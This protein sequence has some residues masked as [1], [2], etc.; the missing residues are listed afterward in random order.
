MYLHSFEAFPEL[1]MQSLAKLCDDVVF[2]MH[3]VTSERIRE[4]ADNTHNARKSVEVSGLWTRSG[5]LLTCIEAAQE[6]EPDI[7]LLPDDDELLPADLRTHLDKWRSSE[8]QWKERFSMSFRQ[9]QCLGDENTIL[10][11]NVCRVGWHCKAVKWFDG[12]IE[13]YQGKYA[14]WCWPS[15]LYR[16]RKIQ[17]VYPMRHLAYA[18]QALID[19]RC[20]PKYPNTTKG[21]WPWY[22]KPRKTMPYDPKMTWKQWE[23]KAGQ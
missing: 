21:Q 22:E 5:S 11:E 1:A 9:F 14:G 17:C 10:A 3:D 2:I 23:S 16:Q 20:D 8:I 7:V 4:A 6:L 19:R 13:A 15:A 12:I 18:N